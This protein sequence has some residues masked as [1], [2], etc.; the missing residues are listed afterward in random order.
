MSITPTYVD[1]TPGQA[2]EWLSKNNTMNRTMRDSK[3][4]AYARDM[5]NGAWKFNGDSI[6]FAEDGTL[7]DGQHRLAAIIRA[8][9]TV[10]F[11][12]VWGLPREA[13]DTMDIGAHRALRDQLHLKGIANSNEVSAIA[14]R[15]FLAENNSVGGGGNAQVGP[16]QAELLDF[17]N[18]N[19]EV[20]R[21]AEVAL[22]SKGNL[23]CAPTAIG[24]AYFMCSRIDVYKAEH[25]WVHQVI[26]GLQLT[27]SD[28]AYALRNR[29]QKEV[30]DGRRRMVADDVYRYGIVAWNHYRAGNPLTRLQA[31][32]GG[33][34]ATALPQPK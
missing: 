10:P 17:I 8:N 7:L 23:P 26:D 3:V 31:P 30:M 4:N 9:V 15:G 28:P 12:V 20:I 32:K 11:I 14:R 34:S 18:A 22:R 6:R 24:T 21:A 27:E 25:F 29:L 5:V 33:W 16:T 2:S 1:V 13:Q 19:P